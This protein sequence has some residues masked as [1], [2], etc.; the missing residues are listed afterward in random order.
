MI[1]NNI[2]IQIRII[3]QHQ[4][5]VSKVFQLL[6]LNDGYLLN[7]MLLHLIFFENKT[8]DIYHISILYKPVSFYVICKVFYK[9]NNFI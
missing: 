3:I 9:Y 8:Q 5:N 6:I 4:Q 2:Q 1:L 7:G